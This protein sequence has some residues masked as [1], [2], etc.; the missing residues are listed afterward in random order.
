MRR[1]STIIMTTNKSAEVDVLADRAVVLARGVIQLNDNVDNLYNH[2]RL[3]YRLCLLRHEL[4]MAAAITKHL[5]ERMPKLRV[6]SVIGLEI[7]L[8]MPGVT[9]A[10]AREF[11]RSIRNEQR[12]LGITHI[13]DP[14]RTIEDGVMRIWGRIHQP[15]Y[16]ATVNPDLMLEALRLHLE[17]SEHPRFWVSMWRRFVALSAKKLRLLWAHRLPLV[18]A[19]VANGVLFFVLYEALADREAPLGASPGVVRLDAA[20][21]GL[22]HSFTTGGRAPSSRAS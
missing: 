1:S 18:C 5:V 7:M 22:G 11:A 8:Y 2:L 14:Y 17:R 13:G 6:L 10:Q 12:Y 16:T 20:S 9:M 4:A 3:G 21:V 19:F 15:D